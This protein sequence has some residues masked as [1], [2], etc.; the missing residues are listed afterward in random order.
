[1]KNKSILGDEEGVLAM[2]ITYST[3]RPGG[4]RRCEKAMGNAAFDAAEEIP[5]FKVVRSMLSSGPSFP[6]VDS[7]GSGQDVVGSGSAV[8][9]AGIVAGGTGVSAVVVVVCLD[10]ARQGRSSSSPHR[11]FHGGLSKNKC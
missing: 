11:A 8:A 4:W 9:A 1:M 3:R 10:H 6:I 7:G 5:K 2:M